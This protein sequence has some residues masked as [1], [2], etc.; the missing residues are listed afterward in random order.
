MQVSA[1]SDVF[2]S[3]LTYSLASATLPPLTINQFRINASTGD[4]CVTSSLNR[5]ATSRY[6]LE[7]RAAEQVQY[8][9]QAFKSLNLCFILSALS[10]YCNQAGPL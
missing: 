7:V 5:E 10:V 1:S 4:V 8:Y 9:Q 3:V 2:T 6:D